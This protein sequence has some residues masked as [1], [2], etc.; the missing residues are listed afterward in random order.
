MADE[1]Q[2]PEATSSR[3]GEVARLFLKL[4]TIAFGG[5]AA[6]I[7]MMDD[8]VVRKRGWVTRERF[9]DL[10][11]ATNLIPGPNSTEMAIHLGLLR[12][13]WRGLIL[14]GACFILPA[15]TIAGVLAWAYVRY[16]ALPEVLWLLYG[17]KPVIIAIVI[18]ALWGFAT[19]AVKGPLTGAVGVV[20]LALSFLGWDEVLLLLVGGLVVMLG[21]RLAGNGRAATAAAVS[22]ATL[23]TCAATSAAAVAASVAVPVSLW[24]LTGFFLK[25][26]SVL[27]GS[28]YVLLAF[29]RGDL[30]QRWGWLTDQ[31]LMDA[32]AVGQFTPGPVFTTATFIGYVV[33]GVPGALLATLGIFLPSFVFVAASSPLIPRMRRSAWAG[34]FLDGVN[35]ASLGLMATVTWQLG[36]AALVDGVTVG[37]AILATVLVFRLRLNSAWLV[38][39]GAVVG[40]GAHLLR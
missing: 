5:P 27:F 36:R 6:H 35:V 38:V 23:G 24:S 29:L 33:A 37:L 8:E 17:V 28:G 1:A 14:A 9:L 7:A 22:V 13:G 39:A 34:S 26:G 25:V 2:R 30:V 11:G 18:Q 40:L 16:G 15:M 12:A 3:V 21:T 10:L 19:K 32:I 31:Q 20:V 4:G